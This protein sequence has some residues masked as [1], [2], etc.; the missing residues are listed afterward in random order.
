MSSDANLEL[1]VVLD[2][3]DPYAFA[4]AE[5]CLREADIPFFV[6]NQI[7]TLVNDVDP[8]ARKWRRIQVASDRETE[9]R[10]IIADVLQP[11]PV[12][13]DENES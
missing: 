6:L 10:Q 3:N 9:A 7:T 8:F 11:V 5:G 12:E 4:L 2:T 1:V 13:P